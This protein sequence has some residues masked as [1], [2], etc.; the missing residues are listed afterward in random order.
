[1]DHYQDDAMQTAVYSGGIMYPVL[2]LAGEAGE[3]AEKLGKYLRD[4]LSNSNTMTVDEITNAVRSDAG[5]RQELLKELGD[6]LWY[7]AA[8]A[9][10]LDS[11]IET[12]ATMNIAKLRSRAVRNALHGSGDNR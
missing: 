9:Q 11:D 2:K 3:V 6:V 7:I 12:V 1:M 8:V 10:E 5:A 4:D